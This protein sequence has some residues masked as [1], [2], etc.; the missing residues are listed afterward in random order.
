M[1]APYLTH[2]DTLRIKAA[3]VGAGHNIGSLSKAINMSRET[4][5]SKINGRSDFS[6]SEMEKISRILG[7]PPGEIFLP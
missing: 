2:A 3:I 6:R 5:S 1:P 4:L 7:I